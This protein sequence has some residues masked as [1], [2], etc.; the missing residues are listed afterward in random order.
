[1]GKMKDCDEP[2]LQRER[3]AEPPGTSKAGRRRAERPLALPEPAK[4][5]AEAE[6]EDP[7]REAAQSEPPQLLA[8]SGVAALFVASDDFDDEWSEIKSEDL[9]LP[10]GEWLL[11]Q[12]W[13][14]VFEEPQL[15]VDRYVEGHPDF[16][17]STSE[18][19]Y[20]P[21]Y[22]QHYE[23]PAFDTFKVAWMHR[24]GEGA[25]SCEAGCGQT[26]CGGGRRVGASAR[27]RR[28]TLGATCWAAAV[29]WC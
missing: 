11:Q 28:H 24:A 2:P 15:A 18:Y 26:G 3:E 21:Y 5:S 1:M 13:L 19:D 17:P 16:D 25:A 23:V 7:A 20:D 29:C 27:S 6:V 10:L 12:D 8:L 9:S 22:V 4:V 14:D